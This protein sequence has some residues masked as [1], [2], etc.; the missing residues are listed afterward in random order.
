MALDL[1]S[2]LEARRRTRAAVDAG[3]QLSDGGRAGRL[4]RHRGRCRPRPPPAP[5]PALARAPD[6]TP[7]TSPRTSWRRCWRGSWRACDER[8]ADHDPIA[9]RSCAR[10]S[11]RRGDAGAS[12]TPPSGAAR[13]PIAIVGDGLPVPGRRHAPRGVL[14]AAAR[15]GGRGPRGA[16]RPLG[17]RGVSPVRARRDG[18]PTFHGG[19]LDGIDRFDAAVLRHLPARGGQHGPA[20]AA[21]ARGELGG[22]RARR[23]GAGP[24]GG[25]PHRRLRRD[26]HHR[27]RR[28]GCGPPT[29]TDLDVY[30]A[31][32]NAHNAAAGRLSYLLGL[33]GPS[34]AVDTACSSSLVAVHLACQSLRLGE[35]D[36]ALAGGVNVLLVPDPVRRLLAVGDDGARRPLQ[37]VRRARRRLRAR[38]RAA[39]SSCSSGWP[40]RSAAGDRVLAVIRGSAV[41]QDGASSGLTVPNGP[42]Q[43]AVVRQ[44]LAAAGVAPA[45]VDYVEAHGTGTSLGD[46]IELEALDAVLGEGRPADRPLVVGSVKTNIGHC[47][48]AVGHGRADQGRAGARARGDPAAPALRDADPAGLARGS[49]RSCRRDRAPWRARRARRAWPA[50]ARSASAAP[51]RTS[52]SRSRRWPSRRRGRAG[53]R[54][55]R[56]GALARRRRPPSASWPRGTR[57]TCS[58]HP[59][60][61]WPTWSARPPSVARSSRTGRPWPPPA[62]RRAA[63]PSPRPRRRGG[64]RRADGPRDLGRPARRRLPVP[65][66]GRAVGGHGPRAGRRRARRPR[67]RWTRAR[68]RCAASLDVP[69]LEVLGARRPPATRRSTRS[70]PCSRSSRRWPRCGARGAWSPR[71]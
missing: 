45:D 71:S 4:P 23:A 2:R 21:A 60:T 50:S 11:R 70:P 41:N 15:R 61:R 55:A 40:T 64:A 18:L 5:A 24:P 62:W 58:A 39:A 1:R 49:R 37:D 27:L 43:Q 31:T 8:R 63:A 54:R 19:F 56:G 42:A 12:S 68:R 46:P 51:T 57:A 9:A 29:P 20:A 59:E 7:T 6:A 52:S 66:P 26:H 53:A 48:S 28:G 16:G 33:R 44:A 25:Q 10:R 47:E 32:G 34:L 3:L 14:G 65:R 13:E 35:S 17:R 22:A 67:R 38:A 69:L 36:L 30:F